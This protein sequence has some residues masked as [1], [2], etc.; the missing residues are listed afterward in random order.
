[1]PDVFKRLADKLDALPQGFPPTDSGVELKILRKIYSPEDAEMALNVNPIP[2]TAET[3]AQRLNR[4]VEDVR[5]TLDDMAH[6]GQIGCLKYSG[7][8]SYM[9]S[10]FV[11]GI[12]EFQVYRMDKELTGLFEEYFPFLIKSTGGYGPG[13]LRTVPINAQIEDS[14]KIEPY[15]NVRKIIEKAKSFKVLDCT[16]RKERAIEG[17]A[18]DHTLENCLGFSME[19]NAYD[20]FLLG[21]RIITKE[22]ALKVLDE[23]AAEGLVH[24]ALYNLKEGH[25]AICNCCP[26][27]CG[28]MRGIK[29]FH[30][31]GTMAKSNFVAVIDPDTCSE[32]GVC[33]EERCPLEAIIEGN[34]GYKVLSDVCIGCGVCSITCPTESITLVRKPE[35]EQIEPPDNMMAWAISRTENR[36]KK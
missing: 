25:A 4:P 22:E 13:I 23:A 29:E 28:M 15:E 35:S 21:G 32:C 10:P 20:Y 14:A 31:P 5:N 8:Q 34:D 27:C 30:A 11:P 7:K 9:L 17:H 2:E 12:Y 6:K 16:C 36:A 26:C 33:A 18:C 24:N 19:E 1:M 3:I